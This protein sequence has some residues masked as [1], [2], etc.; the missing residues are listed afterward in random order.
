VC[1]NKVVGVSGGRHNRTRQQSSFDVHWIEISLQDIIRPQQ[2]IP[3]I[4]AEALLAQGKIDQARETV[5]KA[6]AVR[7]ND[8][9][10]KFHLALAAAQVDA[11]GGNSTLAR[12]MFDAAQAEAEKVGCKMCETELRS[13]IAKLGAKSGSV[14]EGKVFR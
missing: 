8:W 3:A 12:R 13:G 9:L 7:A 11:A 10:A 1:P 5:D 2:K 14:L 6:R 4:Q